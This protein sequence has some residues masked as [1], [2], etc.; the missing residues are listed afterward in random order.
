M[1]MDRFEKAGQAFAELCRTMATLRAP[2]G[3]PWDRE[4][5]FET[6]KT[7]L[8][9]ETYETLEAIESGI[10]EEHCEELGDLLL[11]VVFQSEIAQETDLFDVAQVCDGIRNKL[12]R[13]HPHIF[14]D[15]GA[16]TAKE[17]AETWEEIKAKER[18]G[19]EGKKRS[20]V[21]DGLPSHLPALLRAYR[22][23]E[24]AAGIG[25]DWPDATGPLEKYNEEWIELKEALDSPEDRDSI[26]EELG[27][28][29]F[30]LVNYSRHLGFDP[31]DALRGAI[32]KFH[33]RFRHVE[34]SALSTGKNLRELG[35]DRLNVLWED[36]K[37]LL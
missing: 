19:K 16:K 22:T 2:D 10:P 1:I 29:L 6:L 13:R 27:D 11:Q 28:V 12:V 31:E 33:Q 18:K 30:S 26:K 8:L 7:Y 21:L 32:N 9:E 15:A 3:C 5:T 25:F 36:A 17:V 35:I 24:K 37:R 4:Q 14:G 20:S 34:Q 23:G